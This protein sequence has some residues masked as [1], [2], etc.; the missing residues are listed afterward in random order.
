MPATAYLLAL[1]GE[2][3]GNS[4]ATAVLEQSTDRSQGVTD[5]M[6]YNQSDAVFAEILEKHSL[7]HLE[8]IRSAQLSCQSAPQTVLQSF[9]NGRDALH[10]TCGSEFNSAMG[11]VKIASVMFSENI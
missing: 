9:I 3:S 7:Q 11:D 6:V 8:L 2:L 4:L 1:L 5:M 10:D